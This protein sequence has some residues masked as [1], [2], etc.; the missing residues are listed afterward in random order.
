MMV[1]SML[2]S[3]GN[4]ICFFNTAIIVLSEHFSSFQFTAVLFIV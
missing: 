3:L 2:L 4:H 1:E